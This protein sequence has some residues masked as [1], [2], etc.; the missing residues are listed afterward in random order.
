MVVREPV[1][2]GG[3]VTGTYYT[4][5]SGGQIVIFLP[6]SLEDPHHGLS[7]TA[8]RTGEEFEAE[9]S[10]PTAFPAD[11]PV[12]VQWRTRRRMRGEEHLE[13]EGEGKGVQSY[14]ARAG[15][16]QTTISEIGDGTHVRL[17]DS[18]GIPIGLVELFVKRV[19]LQTVELL[20]PTPGAFLTT[21]QVTAIGQEE[22]ERVTRSLGRRPDHKETNVGYLERWVFPDIVVPVGRLPLWTYPWQATH[23]M[24]MV[25]HTDER[26]LLA[27]VEATKY[28]MHVNSDE[29]LLRTDTPVPWLAE[30]IA[31]LQTVVTRHILYVKDSSKRAGGVDLDTDDWDYP[32]DGLLNVDDCEGLDA[33]ILECVYRLRG[34]T[35]F[36]NPVLQRLQAF[37]RGYIPLFCL[38]TLRIGEGAY[39]YHACTIK[40]DARWLRWKL[41]LKGAA[42]PTTAMLPAL[43][44]EPTTY[45][46]SCRQF[47]SKYFTPAVYRRSHLMTPVESNSKAPAESLGGVYRHVVVATSPELVDE[48]SLTRIDFSYGGREAVPI[49]KLIA[50]DPGVVLTAGYSSSQTIELARRAFECMP[51]LT[52]MRPP[53]LDTQIVNRLVDESHSSSSSSPPVFDTC[54]READWHPGMENELKVAANL[55]RIEVVKLQLTSKLAGIRVRGWD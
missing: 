2:L 52:R 47:R 39:T 11:T 44:L 55:G 53:P 33:L 49:E 8:C 14:E 36:A 4:K 35:V 13:G 37:D 34:P 23:G 26:L 17:R 6:R 7:S 54:Y 51:R 22:R 27:L 5:G 25:R 32:R 31:E 46:T 18:E 38:V 50:Y 3:I 28:S 24:H 21:D 1:V 20:K 40:L 15:T 42:A 41:G 48:L 16:G 10:M 19:R 45:T 29:Q 12:M 30:F 43:V 9:I